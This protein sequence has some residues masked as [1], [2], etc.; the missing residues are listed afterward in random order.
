VG[1]ATI[2]MAFDT[3]G[4]FMPDGLDAA[5]QAMNAYLGRLT[6]E[7]LALSVVG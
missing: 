7:R 1:R 3:Y 6:G 5:A 2:A 4:H